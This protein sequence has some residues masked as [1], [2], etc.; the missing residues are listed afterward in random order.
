MG[1]VHNSFRIAI[2]TLKNF[3]IPVRLTLNRVNMSASGTGL[4]C[5]GRWDKYNFNASNISFIPNK[6]S[7][8]GKKPNY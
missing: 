6:L 7:A 5:I 1:S 3:S 4:T 2:A 8:V